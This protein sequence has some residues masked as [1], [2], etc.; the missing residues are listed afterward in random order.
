MALSELTNGSSGKYETSLAIESEEYPEV[1]AKFLATN[2]YH[3]VTF[4]KT[5]DLVNNPEK[6]PV[7]SQWMAGVVR[8]SLAWSHEQGS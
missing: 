8:D 6:I 5:V 4:G 3:C 7:F 2:P 1:L